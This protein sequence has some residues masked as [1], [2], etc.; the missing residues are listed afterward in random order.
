MA[1]KKYVA[2]IFIKKYNLELF[3]TKMGRRH[4]TDIE[5]HE[6]EL[7][8]NERKTINC[9]LRKHYPELLIRQNNRKP[10]T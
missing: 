2:G 1:P 4:L 6:L 8:K 5:K 3:I 9:H 7:I 10:L